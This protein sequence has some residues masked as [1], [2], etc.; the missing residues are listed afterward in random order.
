MNIAT[1]AGSIGAKHPADRR[2][3]LFDKQRKLME[4]WAVYCAVLNGVQALGNTVMR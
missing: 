4:A 3:D 1:F 2:R